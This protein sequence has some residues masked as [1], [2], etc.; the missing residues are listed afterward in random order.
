[1]NVLVTGHKGYLGGHVTALLNERGHTIRTEAQSPENLDAIIHL[2]WC[3]VP[4]NRH[5]TT[6]KECVRKTDMLLSWGYQVPL[7]LFSSTASVYGNGNDFTEASLTNPGCAYTRAKVEAEQNIRRDRPERFLTFRFG[8]MMGVGAEGGRTRT[9]L[10]VNAFAH[11]GW[12]GKRIEV[13]DPECLK[14]VI[15]V[16]DAATLLVFGMERR[17]T[18]TFN[19]AYDCLMAAAVARTV[20]SLLTESTGTPPDVRFVANDGARGSRSTE[21]DCRRLKETF[22]LEVGGFRTTEEAIR[23]FAVYK[24]QPPAA[25]ATGGLVPALHGPGHGI[26]QG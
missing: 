3:A 11:A 24:K 12:S 8:S 23:E 17:M 25:V 21:V 9:D 15:H 6:Q 10:V 4:G 16:R 18:G 7:F 13:W 5:P 19:A 22:P 20:R 14:P 26:T 2:G 1:M